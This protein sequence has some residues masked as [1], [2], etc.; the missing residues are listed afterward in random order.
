M[1]SKIDPYQPPRSDVSVAQPVGR[2][3]RYYRALNWLYAAIM[4]LGLFF[5]LMAGNLHAELADLFALAMFLAPVA[6]YALSTHG[7]LGM[8]RV[9]RIGH[10][11]FAA[12]LAFMLIYDLVVGKMVQGVIWFIVIYNAAS[13][14]GND[15]F[16]KKR[17]ASPR[18]G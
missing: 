15:Y 3:N 10:L 14:V 1:P 12:V 17:M 11:I 16:R 2:I 9:W 6:G 8:Y 4:A 5:V 13:V 18:Q 7:S